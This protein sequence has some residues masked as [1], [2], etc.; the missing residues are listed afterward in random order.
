LLG[1]GDLHYE[2]KEDQDYPIDHKT[3]T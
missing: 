1:V 3:D 2:D